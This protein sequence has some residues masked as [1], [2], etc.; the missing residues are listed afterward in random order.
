MNLNGYGL[1][2]IW[3]ESFQVNVAIDD[4]IVWHGFL[5]WVVYLLLM[6]WRM[7][8]A[9]ALK[10]LGTD[11]ILQLWFISKAIWCLLAKLGWV[12]K[13]LKGSYFGNCSRSWLGMDVPLW[14]TISESKICEVKMFLHGWFFAIRIIEVVVETKLENVSGVKSKVA[15]I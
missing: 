14:L 1:S 3:L 10:W 12:D 6:L 11:L 13:E 15:K 4:S 5:K 9:G 7:S 8:E 2:V